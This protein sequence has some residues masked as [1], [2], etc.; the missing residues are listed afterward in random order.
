LCVGVG[1]AATGVRLAYVERT[2]EQ[3]SV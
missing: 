2:L 3:G 1:S